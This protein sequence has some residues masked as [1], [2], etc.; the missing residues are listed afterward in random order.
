LIKKETNLGQKESSL[1]KKEINLIKK[2]STLGKKEYKLI[3]LGGRVYFIK[4]DFRL[5]ETRH[6]IYA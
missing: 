4:A 5:L 6:K 2:E 1:I 3:L